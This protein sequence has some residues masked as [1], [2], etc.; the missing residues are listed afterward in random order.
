M[1]GVDFN[2]ILGSR[3]LWDRDQEKVRTTLPGVG[4][5]LSGETSLTAGYA[6]KP[7]VYMDLLLR[8]P[9]LPAFLNLRGYVLWVDILE[10]EG[11][12]GEG[13]NTG[14]ELFLNSGFDSHHLI[15]LRRL[16][17]E[18]DPAKYRLEC[19]VCDPLEKIKK[20]F[21]D[22]RVQLPTQ[23]E[24]S[25]TCLL[26]MALSQDAFAA[27]SA[28]ERREVRQWLKGYEIRQSMAQLGV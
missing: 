18:Y 5:R 3:M 8:E 4:K 1:D 6:G 19:P 24:E 2:P 25:K 28:E 13:Y 7:P 11:A 10:S 23:R 20:E 15:A 17:V 9:P 14:L 16:A 12:P 27:L 26:C 22:W 21:D